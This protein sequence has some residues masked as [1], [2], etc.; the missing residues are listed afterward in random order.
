MKKTVSEDWARE[1]ELGYQELKDRAKENL[2]GDFYFTVLLT[3]AWVVS[4][5]LAINR[6]DYSESLLVGVIVALIWLHHLQRRLTEFY[7]L[8]VIETTEFLRDITDD[9]KKEKK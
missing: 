5:G 8:L 9:V 7:K 1:A 3:V 4:L 6:G 2:K